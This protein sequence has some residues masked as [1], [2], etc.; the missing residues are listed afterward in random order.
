[1]SEASESSV[2]T[3]GDNL[4][5]LM[6]EAMRRARIAP[7]AELGKAARKA[8]Q[9]VALLQQSA[10]KSSFQD[11]VTI[12]NVAEAVGLTAIGLSGLQLHG[13]MLAAVEAARDPEKLM[14]FEVAGQAWLDSRRPGRD[15]GSFRVY[16]T[17]ATIGAELAQACNEMRLSRVDM[18]EG[19]KGRLVLAQALELGRR[20]TATV[21]VKHQ[22]K[23]L[24]LVDRG[25]VDATVLGKLTAETGMDGTT[26]QI[27]GGP[28]DDVVRDA[29]AS[30][31]APATSEAPAVAANTNDEDA[32]PAEAEADIPRPYHEP[33]RPLH[34]PKPR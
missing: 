31:A 5:N 18:P 9:K 6:D 22:G 28:E 13:A 10:A 20:Y 12:G 33:L 19:Y 34:R 23:Q 3:N 15:P 2:A 24:L 32:A 21:Y 1:M 11:K 25:A 17:A 16:V 29:D 14:A 30:V 4:K 7:G 8:Q 26:A 27:A